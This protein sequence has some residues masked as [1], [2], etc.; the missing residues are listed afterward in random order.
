VTTDARTLVAGWFSFPDTGATAG[1]LMA[2]E[3]VCGWLDGAGIAYDVALSSRYGEGVDFTSAEPR[4]YSH[5][6]FVCGPFY[7]SDLLR[8]FER[9]RLV[10]V[11]LSMVDPI[12]DWNPFDL[13][14]ERDSTQA[15]RPDLAIAAPMRPV[16]VVGICLLPP[17]TAKV[18][19]EGY[20]AAEEAVRRLI[21]RR[22]VAPVEIDTELAAGAFDL[23]TPA[24]V[25]SVIARTDVIVSTRLHGLV[26]GLRHGV[27]VLA[28][29][30][31][32]GGERV[33]RQA[34]AL[35]WSPVLGPDRL[36]DASLDEA[37][38]RCLS[39]QAKTRAQTCAASSRATVE[40][41]GATLVAAIRDDRGDPSWGDGRRRGGWTLPEGSV[42]GGGP[43]PP[44]SG[45]GRRALR[46]MRRRLG[47]GAR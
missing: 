21:G 36:D 19:A 39:E 27:P 6:V 25:D 12:E 43:T 28:I 34:D 38:D 26:L 44:T 18:A 3:V 4:R 31:V 42:A 5:V 32:P 14:L 22:D 47:G 7:R 8:R 37:F 24:A 1:D 17:E 30:P 23:R 13:L 45:A 11:D 9:S 10:G 29:D 46:A 40:Q 41:I 16:P 35:G 20:V 33:L 2:M 15:A